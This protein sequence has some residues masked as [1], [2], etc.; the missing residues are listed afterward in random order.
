MPVVS[1]VQ[2]VVDCVS[3]LHYRPVVSVVQTVA[4]CASILCYRPVEE[5]LI[6]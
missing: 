2:T 3:I 6:L 5:N 1:V 4:D